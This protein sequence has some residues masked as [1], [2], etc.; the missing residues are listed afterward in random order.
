MNKNPTKL[1]GFNL[2]Q[3]GAPLFYLFSLFGVLICV[4][5]LLLAYLTIFFESYYI[6]IDGY[7][8][9]HMLFVRMIFEQLA[10]FISLFC[11]FCLSYYTLARCK[12]IA[13]FYNQYDNTDEQPPKYFGFCLTRRK[14]LEN[15][16]IALIGLFICV[17]LYIIFFQAVYWRSQPLVHETNEYYVYI[18]GIGLKNFIIGY[19]KWLILIFIGFGICCYT[20]VRCGKAIKYFTQ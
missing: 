20:L 13:K 5:V 14:Y 17:F 16:I 8:Y 15:F 3:K 6:S 7:V 10:V 2:T 19:L 1:Y 11:A 4:Y 12:K 9:D 18:I